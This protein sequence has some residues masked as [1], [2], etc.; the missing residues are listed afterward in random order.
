MPHLPQRT[1]RLLLAT[2]AATLLLPVA[3]SPAHAAPPVYTC[4]SVTALDPD[5]SRRTAAWGS[6]PCER[7]KGTDVVHVIQDPFILKG[8]SGASYRCDRMWQDR[9]AGLYNAFKTRMTVQ[10]YYCL[11]Q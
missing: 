6:A 1:P 4:A 9:E 7:P 11:R 8:R 3:A 10:G 5:P 2:A